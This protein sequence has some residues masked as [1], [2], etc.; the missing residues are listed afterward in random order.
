[1]N[2]KY[3]NKMQL[4]ILSKSSN[5]AFARITVAAFAAQLDPTIEELSDIKTSVSEA[6]TN[7]IIHGY[8]N[9]DGIIRISA[10]IFEDIVR[11]EIADQGKGIEDIKIAK[12]PLYTTKP[13]LERSGMGFTIMD[14]FMDSLKVE[15]VVGM[16]TKVTMEKKI[17]NKN[18]NENLN[19][20]ENF[21]Y[22]N[23]VGEILKAQN[24][25]EEL[26]RIVENNSGLVWSIVKRFTGRGYENEDLY[27]IGT[28]GL[29]KAIKNFNPEYEVKLSTYAVTYIIGEIKK[30]IRDDGI[31]KVSRS[32]KELCVKIKDIENRNIKEG[33]NVTIEEI[34]RELKVEKEDI[35]L[36]IDSMKQVES[37]YQ[38]ESNDG[39]ISI[40]DKISRS[41]SAIKM[42]GEFVF[43]S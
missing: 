37:I 35:A 7:S 27:Q 40:I 5:E 25:K 9:K 38:E 8:E 43:C 17:N 29:I 22:E 2:K 19:Q 33:K 12:Q 4:E 31:I 3:K 10:Y 30:F 26:G 15:S 23:T 39:K 41:S 36:A 34:A 6:V 16:G 32:I 28:I 11:I 18:T 20:E 21:M 42:T 14:N 24:D 1:M 13:E